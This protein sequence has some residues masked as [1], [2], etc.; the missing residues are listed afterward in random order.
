M[1]TI[2]LGPCDC[3]GGEVFFLCCY[4]V[5]LQGCFYNDPNDDP[6]EGFMEVDCPECG[7][8]GYTAAAGG[9]FVECYEWSPSNCGWEGSFGVTC[10]EAEAGYYIDTAYANDLYLQKSACPES[11]SLYPPVVCAETITVPGGAP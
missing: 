7:E 6:D 4:E 5:G 3:C 2:D 11:A 1:P 10:A 8:P 9:T